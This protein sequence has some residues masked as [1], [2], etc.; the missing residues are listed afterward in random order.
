MTT[1]ISFQGLASVFVLTARNAIRATAFFK[2]PPDSVVE[3]G[4]Q[5]EI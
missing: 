3:L 5:V 1:A 4:V 2:L